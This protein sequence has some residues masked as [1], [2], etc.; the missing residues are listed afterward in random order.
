MVRKSTETN[1]SRTDNTQRDLSWVDFWFEEILFRIR[2]VVVE[3]WWIDTHGPLLPQFVY[4]NGSLYA[5]FKRI[6]VLCEIELRK[7]SFLGKLST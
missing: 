7:L 1:S 3:I 2:V 5:Q 4:V 6:K